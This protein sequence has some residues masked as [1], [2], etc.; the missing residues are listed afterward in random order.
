[1]PA[2]PFW[3]NL[4]RRD[5]GVDALFQA[6]ARVPIFEALSRREFAR[7]QGILHHRTAVAGE[8]L[9]HEGDQGF[10]MYVI[11][12]GQVEIRQAVAHGT[13]EVLAVLAGG[14]FFGEQ[15][16]L[17][18]TPRSASAVAVE[19][20]RVVG[21]F[22]SDL[23]E[24]IEGDPRLGLK[25]VMRLSKM[26]SVRLRHT[27]HLLKEARLQAAAAVAAVGATGSSLPAA[28]VAAVGAVGSSLPAAAAAGV[29]AAG[30]SLPAAAAAAV[31]ATGSSLP[32]VSGRG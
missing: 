10:G 27:N 5:R 6:L 23:L 12:S 28:T 21:F 4:F 7:I 17:D 29:G 24:L 16:L 32:A 30:S 20:C 11:L 13:D 1:M 18:E 8:V 19:P 25:I 31:G 15:A 2:D 26:I 14:D 3:G 9:V 22:R